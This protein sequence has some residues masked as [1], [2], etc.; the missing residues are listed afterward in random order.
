M[1]QLR[2]TLKKKEQ[3]KKKL[4]KEN[5]AR[6]SE[7]NGEPE[8]YILKKN[9]KKYKKKSRSQSRGEELKKIIHFIFYGIHR[10]FRGL[11]IPVFP[12]QGYFSG[13]C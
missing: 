4:K 6:G 5:T 9:Y 13:H 1:Y 7:R 12:V 10:S 3:I 8:I 2:R 11:L